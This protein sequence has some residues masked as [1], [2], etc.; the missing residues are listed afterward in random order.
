MATDKQKEIKK[1]LAIA[2]DEI[3]DIKPWFEKKV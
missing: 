2:L 3:G 1:E